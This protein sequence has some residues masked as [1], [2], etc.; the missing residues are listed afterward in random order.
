LVNYVESTIEDVT[1]LGDDEIVAGANLAQPYVDWVKN[2]ELKDG[3][4]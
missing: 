4:K 3:Q 1:G 2:R